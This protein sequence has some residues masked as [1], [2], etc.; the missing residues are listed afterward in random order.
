MRVE[1]IEEHIVKEKCLLAFKDIKAEVFEQT[2]KK[3]SR[4]KSPKKKK[5]V[6]EIDI[7]KHEENPLDFIIELVRASG[8][9]PPNPEYI[10]CFKD[11]IRFMQ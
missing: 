9:K 6:V 11:F 8:V 10:P 1:R 4:S 2:S 3:K 5:E 7:I